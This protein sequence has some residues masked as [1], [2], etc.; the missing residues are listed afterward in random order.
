MNLWNEAMLGKQILKSAPYKSSGRCDA[1]RK[2]TRRTPEKQ[3]KNQG[4]VLFAPSLLQTSRLSL[5][6]RRALY[7]V[8]YQSITPVT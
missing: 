3:K 2:T 4:H 7:L 5:F 6:H 8:F 1:M